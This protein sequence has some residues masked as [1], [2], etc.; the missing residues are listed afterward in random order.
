MVRVI[1]DEGSH[2]SGGF[3]AVKLDRTLPRHE[4]KMVFLS[5]CTS[6]EFVQREQLNYCVIF[7]KVH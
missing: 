4:V 5:L 2:R 3:M 6:D 7:C 1:D